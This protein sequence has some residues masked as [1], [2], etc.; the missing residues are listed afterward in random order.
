MARTISTGTPTI[1][2]HTGTWPISI[3]PYTTDYSIKA[4][5][6]G[7]TVWTNTK[8]PLDRPETIR[9]A[10]SV[11]KDIY[12]G[13]DIAVGNRAASSKGVSVLSQVTQTWEVTD[14]AD[15][16][17]KVQLPVSAHLVLKM[18]ASGDITSTMLESLLQKLIGS[19]YAEAVALSTGK[20]DALTRGSIL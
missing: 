12:K 7:E 16:T 19:L 2:A 5:I 4:K 10:F 8:S 11:V 9:Q 17:V 13:T 6:P 3:I 14:S 15:A 1:T 20:I 18:P